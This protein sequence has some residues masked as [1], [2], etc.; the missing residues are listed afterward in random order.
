MKILTTQLSGLL[1]RIAEN[2][3]EAFE[4]TA[5]LLAQAT[6]GEGRVL[7]AGFDELS[8]VVSTAVHGVEP[9]RYAQSYAAI[10]M[11]ITAVDR[12]WLLTPSATNPAALALAKQLN[13]TGVP[14]AAL[15]AEKPNDALEL[16]SFA[17]TYISTGLTR[18]LLPGEMGER[19][20]QPHAL[21][22]L[23]VLEAVKLIYNE[24]LEDL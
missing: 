17:E 23:F 12:V 14:F 19:I 15:A 22:A 24:I 7:I 5:R 1:Q 8:A 2:N 20:V 6:V 9:L 11:P 10:D 4:E 16:L 21:A 18:G 13:A 3:E